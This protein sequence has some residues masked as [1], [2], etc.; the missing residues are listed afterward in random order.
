MLVCEPPPRLEHGALNT[1]LDTQDVE[2]RYHAR[3]PEVTSIDGL[4]NDA[5][6]GALRRFCREAT[7]WKKDYENGYCGAFLGDGFASPLLFQIAAELRLKFPGII[8]H[9][10]LTQAWAF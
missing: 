8:N 3:R 2:R 5:A 9:L 6:L 1:A 4:L 10:R 7:I